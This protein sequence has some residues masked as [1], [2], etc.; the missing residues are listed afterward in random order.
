MLLLLLAVASAA[1]LCG[2]AD[3]PPAPDPLG[4]TPGLD[5]PSGSAAATAPQSAQGS[6]FAPVETALEL[7]DAV[8][9]DRERHIEI[10][11]HLDVTGL[12][13]LRPYAFEPLRV[14]DNT[15][16]IRVG[17]FTSGTLCCT[18]FIACNGCPSAR[19]WPYVQADNSSVNKPAFE[20]RA[21]QVHMTLLGAPIASST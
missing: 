11:D 16:S 3:A 10:R 19:H 1:A 9:I 20:W 15:V 13:S 6:Q 5:P 17:T 7:A 14:F 12:P 21:H 18:L 8:N 2:S 4:A